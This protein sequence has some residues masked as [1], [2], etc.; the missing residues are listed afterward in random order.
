MDCCLTD[1]NKAWLF[2]FTSFQSNHNVVGYSPFYNSNFFTGT[3]HKKGEWINGTKQVHN[4]IKISIC[5]NQLPKKCAVFQIMFKVCTNKHWMKKY[6]K[7]GCKVMNFV[8]LPFQFKD[9][10]CTHTCV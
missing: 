8:H 9:S 7:N 4:L 1:K 5:F 3:I 6:A 10:V 2:L